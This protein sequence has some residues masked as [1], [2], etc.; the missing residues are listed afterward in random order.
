MKVAIPVAGIKM[1]GSNESP[2]EQSVSLQWGP[3]GEVPGCGPG[4]EDNKLLKFFQK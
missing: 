2:D 1:T 3:G 4:G